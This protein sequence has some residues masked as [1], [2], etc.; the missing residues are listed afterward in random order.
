MVFNYRGS[1]FAFYS[2][3][4]IGNTVLLKRL[5]YEYEN[6]CGRRHRNGWHGNA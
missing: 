6:S 5:N 2:E 1:F 3:K 4:I